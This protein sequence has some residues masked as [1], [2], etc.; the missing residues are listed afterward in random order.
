MRA[1]PGIEVGVMMQAGPRGS[2]SDGAV[3]TYTI[4]FICIE[5]K[6]VCYYL[7]RKKNCFFPSA[8]LPVT[9]TLF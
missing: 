4:Q 5:R 9:S 2:R 1:G 7:R 8:L 3:R 6:Y